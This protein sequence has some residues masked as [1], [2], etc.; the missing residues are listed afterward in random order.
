MRGSV[1]LGFVFLSLAYL[2]LSWATAC[3]GFTFKLVLVLGTFWR[4]NHLKDLVLTLWR[5]CE[6]EKKVGL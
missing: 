2:L 3:G 6:K 4:M 1:I 5:F